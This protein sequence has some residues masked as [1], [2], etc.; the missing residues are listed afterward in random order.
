MAK[1]IKILG[2]SDPSRLAN[3]SLLTDV[4]EDIIA[5]IGMRPLDK[6]LAVN[7]P[8]AIEKLGQEPF[9]DEG[10]IS[11]LRLLS[12]SHIAIHTWPLR[13]EFHLD[14]YSCREFAPE[15]VYEMLDNYLGLERCKLTDCSDGCEW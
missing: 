11:V 2:I 7:V 3:E 14:V 8:L 13:S 9:E 15:V 1:H 10:G 4:I 6:P 12:T 5:A